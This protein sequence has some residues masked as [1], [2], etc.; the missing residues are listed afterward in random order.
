MG[1]LNHQKL[2]VSRKASPHHPW[3]GEPIKGYFTAGPYLERC[4][5]RKTQA[6]PHMSP[7][8]ASNPVSNQLDASPGFDSTMLWAVVAFF[9]FMQCA[10]FTTSSTSSYDSRANLLVGDVAVDSYHEPTV[11]A[12]IKM[13]KTDQFSTRVIIYLGRANNELCPVTALL[14]YLAIRPTRGGPLF[15]LEDGTFLS[16]SIGPESL[17]SYEHSRRGF[18]NRTVDIHSV[19]A[20]QPQQ[21][22]AG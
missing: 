13:S 18:F 20:R 9:G 7:R 5:E 16:R 10:E 19:S 12:T 3:M 15:G 14:N 8:D 11:I 6:Y 22:L 2:S 1:T 17:S 4:P 21:P